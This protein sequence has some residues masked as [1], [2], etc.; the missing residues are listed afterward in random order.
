MENSIET[1]SAQKAFWHS[2]HGESEELFSSGG[3]VEATVTTQ[4]CLKSFNVLNLGLKS[5][6]TAYLEIW[7]FFNVHAFLIAVV[8]VTDC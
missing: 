1:K 8:M 3:G 5:K 2:F 7:S 4:L 6:C